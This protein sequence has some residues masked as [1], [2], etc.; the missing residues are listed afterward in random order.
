M[1]IIM[2]ISFIIKLTFIAVIYII[3]TYT[4]FATKNRAGM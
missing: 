3:A 2:P 1:I 4:Y